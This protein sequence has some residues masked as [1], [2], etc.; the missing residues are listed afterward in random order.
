MSRVESGSEIEK[1]LQEEIL[2]VGESFAI[3]GTELLGDSQFV[4]PTG[5]PFLDGGGE[6]VGEFIKSVEVLGRNVPQGT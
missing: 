5:Y 2:R 6:A 4:T 1:L 3:R